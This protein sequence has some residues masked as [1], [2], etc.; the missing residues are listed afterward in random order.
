MMSDFPYAAE[1]EQEITVEELEV[2]CY[3]GSGQSNCDST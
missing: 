1:A 3:P 2:G